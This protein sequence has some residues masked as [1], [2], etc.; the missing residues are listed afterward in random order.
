MIDFNLSPC[1]SG[2]FVVLFLICGHG[3]TGRLAPKTDEPQGADGRLVR[4][5]DWPMPRWSPR[6]ARRRTLPVTSGS[7][8]SR[9]NGDPG[10]GSISRTL[11]K[12]QQEKAASP[13][14][15]STYLTRVESR[16]SLFKRLSHQKSDDL[17]TQACMEEVKLHHL[18]Y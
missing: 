13:A 7:P 11:N 1:F 2:P 5:F 14:T 18:F 16:R 9:S 8:R 6:M 17:L 12:T 15:V 10:L 3:G 4:G